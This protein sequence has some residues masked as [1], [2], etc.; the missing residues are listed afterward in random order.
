MASDDV[1]MEGVPWT[2]PS[3]AAK[4]IRALLKARADGLYVEFSSCGMSV[5]FR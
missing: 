2:A 5:S 3:L 1:A 4:G